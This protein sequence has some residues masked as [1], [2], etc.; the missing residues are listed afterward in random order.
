MMALSAGTV[1]YTDCMSAEGH[2][3][4]ECPRY[5]I[6]QSD[7]GALVMMELWGMRSTPSQPSLACPLC[8]GVVASM[9]QIELNCVLIQN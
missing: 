8:P 4:P 2:D 6:K 5:D 9:G 7:D 1:E 3:S